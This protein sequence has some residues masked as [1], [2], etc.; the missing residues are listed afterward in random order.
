MHKRLTF[1]PPEAVRRGRQ[2]G[3]GSTGSRAMAVATRQ[4]N[5]YSNIIAVCELMNYLR[6]GVLRS[7][8]H[9][10]SSPWSNRR[11]TRLGS[12]DKEN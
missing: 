2:G 5:L 8:L 1:H 7:E 9:A 3:S 12:L 4:F 6:T 11:L 10:S